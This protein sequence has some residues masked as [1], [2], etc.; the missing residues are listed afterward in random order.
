MIKIIYAIK[1]GFKPI[2]I[3]LFFFLS[4]KFILNDQNPDYAYLKF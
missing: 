1:Y 4:L 2:Q 3:I